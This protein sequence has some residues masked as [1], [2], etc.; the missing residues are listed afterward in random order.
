[1]G[2]EC[3]S[4]DEDYYYSDDEQDSLNDDFDDLEADSQM[5]APKA[6]S[7]KVFYCFYCIDRLTIVSFLWVCFVLIVLLMRIVC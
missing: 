6:P 4:I 7:T 1:M 2:E 3:T 5:I